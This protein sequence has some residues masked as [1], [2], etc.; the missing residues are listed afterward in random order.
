MTDDLASIAYVDRPGAPRLAYRAS[1]GAVPGPTVV[2]CGGFR[3]DME[4]GKAIHLHAWAKAAGRAYVRFDYAGHGSSDGA[5]EDG[6]IGA[7][8]DDALAVIDAATQ[9]PLLLVGSSMGGW[10]ALLIALARP[11]RVVG[12][13]L[14]APAP[15]FTE[16]LMWPAFT[17]A[18]QSQLRESGRVIRPSPY[19]PAG[20]VVTMRLIEEGRAHLLLDRPPIPL[21]IPVRILQGVEDDAVPWRLALELT[22]ALAGADVEVTLVKSG[23]HRLSEPADLERLTR[24]VDALA[25][26]LSPPASA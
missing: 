21:S 6:T 9:G 1:P 10:I 7:W 3:S 24:T 19:D 26:Q 20:D 5:F 15:D 14:I 2:W 4:G 23:D 22:E 18:E 12:L 16:R 17:E 11:E 8:R 25:R 13:T